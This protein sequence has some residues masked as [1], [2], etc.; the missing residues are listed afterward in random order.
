MLEMLLFN[1]QEKKAH[2]VRS[3][4]D[5]EKSYIDSLSRIVNVRSFFKKDNAS[6]IYF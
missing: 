2:V 6:L 5:S 4:I 3:I 1:F